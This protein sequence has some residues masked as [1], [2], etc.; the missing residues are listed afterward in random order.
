MAIIL[1]ETMTWQTVF[2]IFAA[3]ILSV[4][5][6]LPFMRYPERV[7]KDEIEETLSEVLMIAFKDP[8][9]MMIL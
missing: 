5:L 8:T 4:I 1:L 7:S 2:L 3:S 9:Y 6:L